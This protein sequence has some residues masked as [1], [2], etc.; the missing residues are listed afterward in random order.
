MAGNLDMALEALDVPPQLHD[1]MV[2]KFNQQ[3]PEVKEI[4]VAATG[5]E[6][7]APAA[8]AT[9][10]ANTEAA[11]TETPLEATEAVTAVTEKPIEEIADDTIVIDPAKKIKVGDEILSWEQFQ[12]RTQKKADMDKE[13]FQLKKDRELFEVEK[14][15]ADSAKYWK[16]FIE[17]DAFLRSYAQLTDSGMSRD[18]AFA[19]A[20]KVGNINLPAQIAPQAAEAKNDLADRLPKLPSHIEPNSDEHTKWYTEVYEPAKMAAVAEMAGEKIVAKF[21]SQRVADQKVAMEAEQKKQREAQAQSATQSAIDANQAQINQL[22]NMLW[23]MFGIDIGKLTPEQKADA[24]AR[25]SGAMAENSIDPD[26]RQWMA[27]HTL[28]PLHIKGLIREAFPE[29]KNPYI[30]SQKTAAPSERP[31]ADVTPPHTAGRNY[32]PSAAPTK[33][34]ERYGSPMEAAVA[35][36][37]M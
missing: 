3:S 21:E 35:S 29:G 2:E 36:L 6:N 24:T 15:D 17:S 37:D 5:G 8:S 20:M 12:L 34:A 18:E 16:T 11:T 13:R 30:A 1:S 4:P 10:A 22:P 26:D 14:Q 27:S 7:T 9:A 23:T 25:L 31:K 28:E 19:A 32:A 33:G